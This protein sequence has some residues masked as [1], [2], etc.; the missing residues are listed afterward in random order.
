MMTTPPRAVLWDMDGTLIDS[1]DYHYESWVDALRPEHL[2]LTR[3]QFLS[4]FG[5]KNERILRRWVG[6]DIDP[7]RLARIADAKE[8][9]Y[10]AFLRERGLQPLAGASEWI[11]RLKADGWRQAIASSAPGANVEAAL[12]VLGWTACF[13]AV[14]AGEDV[15]AGKPDPEIF[16]IAAARLDA[17]PSRC[18]VVEDAAAGVQA[19]RR[20][21]MR[22]I[23]V[24]R[25]A[26][27]ERPD[28]SVPSLNALEPDAFER[29]LQGSA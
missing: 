26:A 11:A 1:A 9:R 7:A 10:R 29:L 12:D 6:S 3:E 21:G 17:H 15:H 4:T 22:C 25:A 8:E 5:W 19:A 23:G 18:I 2:T 20:G 24:G 16:L 13:D 14:A 27:T 28:I